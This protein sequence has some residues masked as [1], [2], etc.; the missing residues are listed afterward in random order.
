MAQSAG[1]PPRRWVERGASRAA[2]VAPGDAPGGA[3]P[4]TVVERGGAPA[5]GDATT[6]S[7][8][9]R[10]DALTTSTITV[11]CYNVLSDRYSHSGFEY[12]PPP[13]RRW[14]RRFRLL[15]AEVAAAS[16]D[17]CALQE[18]ES[19]A[20]VHHFKPWFAARGYAGAY[21]HNTARVANSIG[22]AVFY[23]TAVF[24]CV[25]YD[26]LRVALLAADPEITDG[27]RGQPVRPAAAAAPSRTLFGFLEAAI[28]ESED[29]EVEGAEAGSGGGGRVSGAGS[30]QADQR[31]AWLNRH[32]DSHDDLW[33]EW[34][35]CTHHVALALTLQL[36]ER[37]AWGGAPAAL[38]QERSEVHVKFDVDVSDGELPL[39]PLEDDPLE[40]RDAAPPA[41][42]AEAEAPSGGAGASPLAAD[43][44]HA[45]P[46][47]ANALLLQ[48]GAP[49]M[50]VA[51]FH[52]YWNPAYPEIK[53]M[54]TA[55]VARGV[56]RIGRQVAAASGGSVDPALLLCGDFNTL[57]HISASTEHDRVPRGRPLIPGAYQL[58][59]SGQLRQA[60]PHHPVG[61]RK[62]SRLALRPESVKDLQLAHAWVSAYAAVLGR[63]PAWTNWHTHAFKETLDYV[64]V[65]HVDGEEV[66][67]ATPPVPPFAPTGPVRCRLVPSA[68][69]DVPSDEDVL[70]CE[71]AAGGGCPNEGCPSDHIPLVVR[72]DVCVAGGGAGAGTQ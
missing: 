11:M 63:E 40:H 15:C 66:A 1:P 4:P 26:P 53:T 12:C 38:P 30:P 65:A 37:G 70:R 6:G 14:S 23:R 29:A 72:F 28:R 7:R 57:P 3:T 31:D 54:Q 67:G 69:L 43:T 61:R 58:L 27:M 18:V 60:H 33:E 17:V 44:A 49:T 22:V 39:G 32:V 21:V 24:D 16:P 52:A 13:L 8:A 71:G 64:F 25:R 35:E 36:K 42:A 9:G 10:A 59:V 48:P 56:E 2:G 47:A 20:Y 50:V 34:L 68:V 19:G 5:E 55:L 51:C 41:S 45:P 62:G 46:P